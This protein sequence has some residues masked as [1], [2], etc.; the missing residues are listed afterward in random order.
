MTK[1]PYEPPRLTEHGKLG[2]AT[3]AVKGEG[4]PDSTRTRHGTI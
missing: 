1:K 4:K 3:G 2:Q